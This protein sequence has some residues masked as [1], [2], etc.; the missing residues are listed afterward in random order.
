MFIPFVKI[1]PSA[2][3]FDVTG[4]KAL[5]VSCLSNLITH[6]VGLHRQMY[7]MTKDTCL[8][9]CKTLHFNGVRHWKQARLKLCSPNVEEL[10]L[11]SVSL[12]EQVGLDNCAVSHILTRN[13]K[14]A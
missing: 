10:R 9:V 13:T 5:G 8:N 7:I 12:P 1:K 4:F 11:S 14:E 3:I 6:Q 2:K